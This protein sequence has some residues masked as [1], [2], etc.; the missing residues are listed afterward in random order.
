M[1][2]CWVSV[3]GVVGPEA[4]GG[5]GITTGTVP[6]PGAAIGAWAAGAGA[7]AGGACSVG[8]GAA[9]GAEGAVTWTGG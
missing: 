3:K 2:L 8:T 1:C 7:G 6:T 4:T 5:G 9:T